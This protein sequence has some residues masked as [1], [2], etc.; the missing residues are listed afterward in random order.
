M[1]IETVNKTCSCEFCGEEYETKTSD[2][3]SPFLYCSGECEASDD[4]GELELD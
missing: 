4:A 2:A 3:W 1:S